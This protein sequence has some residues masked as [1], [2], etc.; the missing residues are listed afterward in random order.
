MACDALCAAPL[1]SRLSRTTRQRS[2]WRG[3]ASSLPLLLVLL[4]S[5]PCGCRARF[6]ADPA[7]A[8]NPLL[9]KLLGRLRGAAE[10]ASSSGL[11]E[12]KARTDET[13]QAHKQKV[14]ADLAAGLALHTQRIRGISS[15]S[16]AVLAATKER[17][18]A[19]RGEAAVRS[20]LT[21]QQVVVTVQKESEAEIQTLEQQAKA[22][23]AQGAVQLSDADSALLNLQK[24][25][26]E[27]KQWRAQWPRDKINSTIAVGNEAQE[28]IHQLAK[29]TAET[30]EMDTSVQKRAMR[31][32]EVA[33]EA[34][35]RVQHA[36]LM[37]E[38]AL[39]MAE[40]NAIKLQG[41]VSLV[42][43]ASAATNAANMRSVAAVS[44]SAS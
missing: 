35:T 6:A 9:D 42:N 13:L 14:D 10:T 33:H 26:A 2:T 32:L 24:A 12:L 44:A 28:V 19:A 34:M 41:I 27:V 38:Q 39:D 11:A 20:K 15:E 30:D 25:L 17:F 4:A 18:K 22:L 29:L 23:K 7:D 16:E 31:V 21:A 37:S 3:S 1:C 5:G 43:G 40:Q 8:G 36:A